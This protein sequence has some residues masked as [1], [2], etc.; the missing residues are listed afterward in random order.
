M[1][2]YNLVA[3]EINGDKTIVL[4]INTPVIHFWTVVSA[5]LFYDKLNKDDS[6]K[7]VFV[8]R[9]ISFSIS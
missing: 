3:D 8:C 2:T 4:S 5:Y 6:L 1:S 9:S 7:L